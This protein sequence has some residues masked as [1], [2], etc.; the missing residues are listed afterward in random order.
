MDSSGNQAPAVERFV[1]TTR[2]LQR[3]VLVDR[4][5][6]R[7]ARQRPNIHLFGAGFDQ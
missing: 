6:I 7:R 1:I 3:P 2:M 4:L 5:V